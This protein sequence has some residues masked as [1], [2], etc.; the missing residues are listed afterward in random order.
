MH[1][2]RQQLVQSGL[3]QQ[4]PTVLATGSDLL[5]AWPQQK[6]AVQDVSTDQ[7]SSWTQD[8]VRCLGYELFCV[9]KALLELAADDPDLTAAVAAAVPSALQL[10]S[11][12]LQFMHGQLLCTGPPDPADPGS[13]QAFR[14][15]HLLVQGGCTVGWLLITLLNQFL[16]LHFNDRQDTPAQH[17][18]AQHATRRPW[19][20][21]CLACRTSTWFAASACSQHTR[22]G[23]AL[24]AAA[25]PQAAAA[26]V[27]A[28]HRHSSSS[29]TTASA[30][31]GSRP[32]RRHGRRLRYS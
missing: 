11:A 28:A 16:A 2:L 10:L 21:S 12:A 26:A 3:T 6:D 4:L 9:Y 20:A 23:R 22:C 7:H 14:R 30:S 29:T 19:Q 24:H 31:S 5:L 15:L 13:I 27:A 1:A 32:G 17:S 18:T 8:K 25:R